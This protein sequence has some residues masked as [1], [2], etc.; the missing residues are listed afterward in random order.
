MQSRICAGDSR[1]LGGAS[2]LPV[3][4]V[5]VAHLVRAGYPDGQ[6][7][8]ELSDAAAQ[9]LSA[10]E[11]LAQILRGFGV[12]TVP[13]MRAE[14]VALY[15]TLTGQRRVLLVFDDARDEAQIRDLIP[16]NPG[17]GVLVTAR[18]RLPGTA[19]C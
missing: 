17:C 3:L 12:T 9:H 7:Y 16:G 2:G 4:A 1:R 8:L 15:R 19:R 18:S 6:L 14:R 10:E 5:H 11:L 13:Q